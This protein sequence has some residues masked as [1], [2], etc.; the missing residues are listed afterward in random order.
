MEVDHFN[1]LLTGSDRHNYNNLF[2]ATRHCN[3]SKRD[4]WPSKGARKKGIHFLNPCKEIDYGVHIVEHPITHR[5]I[6]ISAAGDFHITACDLNA[7]H[8]VNE[9]RERA[10]IH[11]VL[12]KTGITAK[13]AVHGRWSDTAVLAPIQSLRE[14]V[15]K[16][17]PLIPYLPKDHPKYEEEL[18]V[19]QLLR[20]SYGSL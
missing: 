3:G 12:T 13:G 2:L 14:Q 4:T 10:A 20:N 8:L 7:L 15:E 11:E 17:I 9:R 16:M 6:G 18:I 1:P 5:L 19:M